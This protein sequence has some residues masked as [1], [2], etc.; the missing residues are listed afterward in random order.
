MITLNYDI[1]T[2]CNLK[3]Q[4]CFQ[5]K[6]GKWGI[7]SS[8]SDH[9]RILFLLKDVKDDIH[10]TIIG[11]EPSLHP[12]LKNFIKG[13]QQ[14]ECIKEI[15][16]YT[17]AVKPIILNSYDKIEFT[18]STHNG[19]INF[20]TLDYYGKVAKVSVIIM[21]DDYS[22]NLKIKDKLKKYNCSFN[23]VIDFDTM[24]IMDHPTF[25]GFR[26]DAPHH[27]KE[28]IVS[29][30]DITVTGDILTQCLQEGMN[31]HK[32]SFQDVFKNLGRCIK[33]PEKICM[34]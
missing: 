14:T 5:R 17:N 12:N 19:K 21:M 28:C 31:I 26:H 8:K 3:C 9:E 7:I 4:Y 30:F 11:G 18:C 25:C 32:N 34:N 10:F 16:I 1:I 2:L 24:K 23:S 6:T 13:L 15:E 22:A 33:C 29:G 27:K 20:K